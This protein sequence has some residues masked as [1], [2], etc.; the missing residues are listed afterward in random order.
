MRNMWVRLEYL[1]WDFDEPGDDLLGAKDSTLTANLREPFAFT[2]IFGTVLGAV[3]V[4]NL[5]EITLKDIDG[6]RLTVGVPLREGDFEI[7]GFVMEQASD[8]IIASLPDQQTAGNAVFVATSTLLNGSAS[9]VILQFDDFFEARFVSELW[10]LESKYQFEMSP[11]WK[12]F[13]IDPFITF[14][15]LQLHESL[16][17][18]GGFS[19]IA[20]QFG[21]PLPTTLV[22]VIDSD[23]NNHI[24]G[25][26]LGLY[27]RARFPNMNGRLPQVTVSL[28]PRFTLGLNTFR[29]RVSAENVIT[30]NERVVTTDNKTIF[31]PVMEARAQVKIDLRPDFSIFGGYNFLYLPYVTRPQNNIRYNIIDTGAQ[32]I[33]DYVVDTHKQEMGYHGWNVGAEWRFR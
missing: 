6:L 19:D 7:S 16:H 13:R 11:P 24:Y 30:A 33:P 14:R 5:R 17:Q 20:G 18:V 8:K 22:T 31:S 12:S 21:G 27:T 23:S 3:S 4:P 26:G 15:Y 28:E 32:V 9:G 29:N 25:P 2:D 10:G 1:T